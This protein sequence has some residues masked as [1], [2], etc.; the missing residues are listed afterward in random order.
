MPDAG[1]L[2][3]DA[4]RFHE[5][6]KTF[7]T[8][9]QP[10]RAVERVSFGVARGEFLAILGP[11]GCGKST[12]LMMAAGLEA[13]TEGSLERGGVP[14]IGPHRQT[15]VMFQDATLLPWLSVLDNVLFPATI[16]RIPHAKVMDRATQLIRTTGL[17]GFERSR[18]HELSGGM[19]QRAAIC[20]ALVLDPDLLLMDEPFSALDAITRD[21][22]GDV[23]LD[24]WQHTQKSAIF[25]TH[26]IREAVLLA[27]RVLVMSRRPATIAEELVVPFPRPRAP[28]LADT[29]EFTAVVAHLRGVI[30]RGMA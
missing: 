14:L 27:D 10:L 18:P 20:R 3:V 13:P 30:A 23:L 2:A 19:R 5:V 28:G 29:P 24:L 1:P 7:P 21:E 15:G 17:A 6:G 11:S 16:R 25:V 8:K 4:V 22:M 12:L 9:P 26:S